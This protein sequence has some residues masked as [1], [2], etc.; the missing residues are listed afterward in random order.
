L[1]TCF[2]AA[3]ALVAK[4]IGGKISKKRKIRP[5]ARTNFSNLLTLPLWAD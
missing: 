5:V 1:A 4:I 3:N 2:H